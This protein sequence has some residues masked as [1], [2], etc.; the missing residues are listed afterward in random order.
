MI[1]I[2][3]ALSTTRLSTT[4]IVGG[5]L[6]VVVVLGVASACGGG[7]SSGTSA[8]AA[9]TLT[10]ALKLQQEGKYSDAA[11]LYQQVIATQPG[12]LYA[13]YDLGVVRQATRDSVGALSA[14]GAA[15]TIN[16]KY[17]PAL[18][19]EATIYATTDP[20]LAISLYRQIVGLQPIAPTAY[21][22]LGFLEIKHGAPKQGA[23]DLATAVKQDSA[24]LA[25]VPK[26][27]QALVTSLNSPAPTTTPS[28]QHTPKQSITPT[29]SSS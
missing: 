4:R 21:L 27:L 7:S 14:Y 11:Q 2:P 23:R 12:N 13:Q 10:A 8:N 25:R 20:V 18:Y 22:N 15:L 29:T 24:L 28:S 6:A 17:V 16:P 1:R 26:N 3:T 19:N 5:I 9:T